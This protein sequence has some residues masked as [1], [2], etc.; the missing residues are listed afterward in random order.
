VNGEVGGYAVRVGKM[1]GNR[2]CRL[3]PARC[4]QFDREA[5][6]EFAGGLGVGLE[7]GFRPPVLVDLAQFGGVRSAIA[8]PRCRSGYFDRLTPAI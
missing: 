6:K 4:R 2:L 5:E 7:S 8:S 1:P 3:Q